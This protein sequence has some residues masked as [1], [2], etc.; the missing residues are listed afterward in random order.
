MDAESLASPDLYPIGFDVRTERIRFIRLDE[1]RY[2]AESFLDQR[3]LPAEGEETW[4]PWTDVQQAGERYGGACDF[5]FHIG[6][7]GSTLLSR[8]LGQSPRVFSLREPEVLRDLARAELAGQ[9]PER[10]AQWTRTFLRMWG[11]VYRPG[12]KTLLKATSF[13]TELAPLIMRLDPSASAVLMLVSP[14]IYLAGILS[15]EGAREEAR[16]KGPMQ[17]SRLHR[18]LG[19]PVWRLEDMSDGEIVAMNWLC[20]ISALSDVGAAC[21]DRVVWLDFEAFLAEPAQG[22]A[23]VLRRLHGEA[24]DGVV[25]AMLQSA[26]MRR[27]SK[28]PE[29]SYDA[30]LRRRVLA[31]ASVEHQAEID[32]GIQWLNAAGESHA[33]L[34]QA[35]RHV[36]AARTPST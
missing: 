10:L 13:A 19:R 5:I 2:A 27:Y 6:H 18:R 8:L 31:Q 21:P 15:S 17:V 24:P 3:I 28:A 20:E 14:S 34:A 23:R 7:V 26:D 1:A 22:L 33:A 9:E 36:A 16:L 32:R 4:L 29:F 12:Q 11:R 30:N 25:S 35:M